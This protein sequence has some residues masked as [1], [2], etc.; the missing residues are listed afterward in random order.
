MKRIIKLLL[1]ITLVI[2]LLSVK[3]NAYADNPFITRTANRFGE[4]VETQDAYEAILKIKDFDDYTFNK[5]TDIYIDSED[6]IYIADSLNKRIIVAD[7]NN[8]FVTSFGTSELIDPRGI[9]VRYNTVYVADYG[10]R[11]E[12]KSEP[13]KI[14]LYDLDKEAKTATLKAIRTCPDSQVLSL[15]NFDFHPEKIAVDTNLTMYVVSDGSYSG[16]L[17]I[18]DENRFISYFAPNN[19][20]VDLKTRITQFLYGENERTTLKAILPSPPYNVH[21]DDS[22]YIYT[23]SQMVIKNDLGDTL[24]K[25]NI[26]GLNFYPNEM[27]AASD[28]TS[29]WSG[30]YGNVYA[31]TKS[32]F[33]YE[34]DINGDLLFTFAGKQTTIDQLG[35]F[36]N[37]IGLAVNSRDELYILDQN[38]NSI[39]IF[40]PTSLTKTVHEA[41]GLFNE[42]RYQESQNLWEEVLVYNSMTDIAHKGIG[43]SYFMKGEYKEALKEFKLANDKKNYSEAFW[44]I[45]NVW[46]SSNI[47]PLFIIIMVIVIATFTIII[48]NQKKHI[49]APIKGGFTKLKEKKPIN[50]FL[51]MFKMLRHPLDATYFFKKDKKIR[52]YNG[53]IVLFFVFIIYIIGLVFTGFIFNNVVLERTILLKEAF[54][55]LI[56]IILFV[57]SNYLASSLLE[58]EGTFKA[59]FLTTMGCLM[60]II[61]IYPFLIL[62]SNYITYSESF[63]FYFGLFIM[64]TWS[65]VLL[66]VVNKELHNYTFKKMILNIIMTLG[67]M[68][69]LLIVVILV[70]LL[71]SQ[72]VS[73]VQDI[74]SEAIFHD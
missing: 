34:Y 52:F 61:I 62:V 38:D 58:G 6:Y 63:I 21:I 25:V 20:S 36:K 59:V 28:F 41:L 70:Y 46:I 1:V 48:L 33:I 29:C 17:T 4:L 5:P 18:N 11:S 68:L 55:I 44:E 9:F 43:L 40:R 8:H 10:I 49:L 69:V 50:D 7:A 26:G 32:G 57:I 74:I 45:R 64:I 19:V 60:P 47:L 37:I 12:T 56:P 39:Q 31:S 72:V 54:K 24:K 16:V 35:L 67:L 13:G 15:S 22:G 53:L 42:G 3:N 14:V 66:I 23:V 51:L 30:K 2:T 73:F 65:L 71:V 27:L